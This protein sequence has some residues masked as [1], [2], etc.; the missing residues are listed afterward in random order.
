MID[1]VKCDE[2]FLLSK[3]KQKGLARDSFIAMKTRTLFAEKMDR[4]LVS[5][6]NLNIIT[7]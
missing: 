6:L 3:F 5:V 4:I 7:L 2:Y 1:I